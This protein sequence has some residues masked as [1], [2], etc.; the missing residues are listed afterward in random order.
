MDAPNSKKTVPGVPFVKG[1]PRINRS[2]RP[3]R[4]IAAEIAQTIFESCPE[5]IVKTFLAK[6]K[7]GD[8]RIF[9]ALADRAYGKAPES[10]T[11]NATVE[12]RDLSNLTD[13]QLDQVATIIE[14]ATAK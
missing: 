13:E 6:L 9:T 2:G 8:S 12:H 10:I 1:D 5:Q 14:S 4:D 11:V 3:K 7:K